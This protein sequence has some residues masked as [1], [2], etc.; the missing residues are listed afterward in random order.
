M[1]WMELLDV[2]QRGFDSFVNTLMQIEAQKAANYN[3][4]L[5]NQI[6]KIL[7]DKNYDPNAQQGVI[8][9]YLANLGYK[10]KDTKAVELNEMLNKIEKMQY[11][12]DYADLYGSGNSPR[13]KIATQMFGEYNADYSQQTQAAR[14]AMAKNI[15]AAKANANANSEVVQSKPGGEPFKPLPE[16]ASF[17]KWAQNNNLKNRAARRK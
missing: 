8:D 9:T 12:S 3:A 2:N 11:G 15:A 13:S 14:D 16:G 1:A 4:G 5:E 7:S 10:T 17:L 6:T